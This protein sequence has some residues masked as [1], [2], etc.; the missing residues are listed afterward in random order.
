METYKFT[1]EAETLVHIVDEQG[2]S[3]KTMALYQVP[4]GV[5]IHPAHTEEEKAQHAIN[6]ANNVEFQALAELDK[7]SVRDMREWIAS[8]PDAPQTLKDR[9]SQAV[10]ARGRLK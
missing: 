5:T 3:L 7:Q 9:E 8:Q 6:N 10:A 1:D 4:K 2:N